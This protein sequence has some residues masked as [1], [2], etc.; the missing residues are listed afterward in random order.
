MDNFSHKHPFTLSDIWTKKAIF[1]K[2]EEN[3]DSTDEESS[4]T[5]SEQALP[6]SHVDFEIGQVYYSSAA[7]QVHVYPDQSHGDVEITL[8]DS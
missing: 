6:P 4:E 7:K 2:E 8:V 1:E 3:L 5:E